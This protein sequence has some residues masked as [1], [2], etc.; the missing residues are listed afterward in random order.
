MT[1][2]IDKNGR[3]IRSNLPIVDR[4]DRYLAQIK[5]DR[6]GLNIFT[7]QNYTDGVKLRSESTL[8]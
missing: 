2:A 1:V 7:G 6:T 4:N 5:D 3:Y 8:R